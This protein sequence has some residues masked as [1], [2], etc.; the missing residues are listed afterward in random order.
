MKFWCGSLVEA[1]EILRAAAG[2]AA[3]EEPLKA[4]EMLFDA[5]EAAAWAG[6]FERMAEIG[7][8]AASVRTME[9]GRDKF[10]ANL[11]IG[12]GGLFE[13]KTS[14]ELPMISE[15]LDHADDFD[16]P[17]WLVWAASSAGVAGDAPREADLLRRA[18]AIARSSG[19]VD[20]LTHVLVTVAARGVFEGR[21]STAREAAWE[22]LTLAR[23]AG[24]SNAAAIH[25]AVLTWVT[26]V[27]GDDLESASYAA[28]VNEL[29]RTAGAGFAN[30]IAEWGIGLLDLGKGRPT[31]AAARLASVGEARPGEGQQF[32]ALVSAAD[33]VEAYVRSDRA[34][35]AGLP[36]ARLE[37]F[38]GREG[39]TWAVALAA[40]CRALLEPAPASAELNY[41]EALRLH[42]DGRRQFDR[43]RTEL[44]YGEH[45]RRQ[46]RR[47][48]SREHLR[49]ALE[50]FETLGAAPWAER[51]RVEL[52]ASGETAR[53]RDPS[54]VDQLTPQELQ[55]A[56]LVGE[57]MSNKEVAAQLFLSPRTID[58][59]LRKVFT[60]LEITSRTELVRLGVAEERE[61]AVEAV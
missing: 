60:K 7:Q 28:E 59:H 22:G 2:E 43:A 3:Q 32:V 18:V 50:A 42:A 19:A 25:L 24:L 44:L 14:S 13:G 17:R 15:V 46:R 36:A 53:K 11:L 12:V 52:R 9:F 47:R 29:S 31:D 8:Q 38:A 40:R 57:G 26:A 49:A 35:E 55:I 23:E 48:E 41:Q 1:C 33:L 58:Y 16:E 4:L 61:P 21:L 5:A 39:P 45:L 30:A 56:R 6:D 27:R 51:A 34:E 54:T 37:G 20:N 10:L